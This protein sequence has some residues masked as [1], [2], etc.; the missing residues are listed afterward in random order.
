MVNQIII[1]SQLNICFNII[2]IL[3]KHYIF[4]SIFLKITNICLKCYFIAINNAHG[5]WLIKHCYASS[6]SIIIDSLDNNFNQ[7]DWKK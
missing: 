4:N 5:S 2:D 7:L 3:L 1:N 6:N